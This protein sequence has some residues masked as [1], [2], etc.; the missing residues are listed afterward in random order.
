MTCPGPHGQDAVAWLCQNICEPHALPATPS[1]RVEKAAPRPALTAGPASL[2]LCPVPAGR[3][4]GSSPAAQASLHCL[5]PF[6]HDAPPHSALCRGPSDHQG[7]QHGGGQSNVEGQRP[8]PG[9]WP[10][11]RPEGKASCTTCTLSSRSWRQQGEFLHFPQM[12]QKL[13]HVTMNAWEDG[14]LECS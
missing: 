12:H 11:S 8:G 1:G 10:Q 7:R 2:R 14:I 13:R 9:E 4:D 5:R 6:P 3:R